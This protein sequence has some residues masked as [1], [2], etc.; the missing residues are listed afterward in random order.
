MCSTTESLAAAVI[1]AIAGL[2]AA[3]GEAP[4]SPSGEPGA[5]DALPD[6]PL[7][8]RWERLRSDLP[9]EVWE[10][11]IAYDPRTRAV[12][13]HGGHVIG[14]YVQ[15]SYTTL[16]ELPSGEVR[17]STAGSRPQR[18]C[19]VDLV[20]LDTIGRVLTGNGSSSHGSLPQGG[21]AADYRSII[22]GDPRGPF[23]YDSVTDTWEDARTIGTQWNRIPHA[24]LA[25]DPVHEAVVY[26]AGDRLVMYSVRTNRIYGRALPEALHGR[27]A[28]GI[29]GT[30]RHGEV[31][32]FGGSGPRSWTT[33]PDRQQAYDEYVHDDT[34]IY[35]IGADAWEEVSSA[36][37]PPKGMPM[38][39]FLKLD[40]VYYEPLDR[41][42]LWTVPVSA[43]PPTFSDW[44][45]P[46]L[47]SFDLGT[48][49]WEI[50]PSSGGPEFPGLLAAA[51]DEE[52]LVLVGGGRDGPPAANP[53][54][55]LSRELW[56]GEVTVPRAL[57]PLAPDPA[58]VSARTSAATVEL[59]WAATEGATYE[60]W[61]APASPFPG[62]FEQVGTANGSSWTDADVEP[63]VVHAYRVVRAG[64]PLSR[65]SSSVFDQPLR[66]GGVTAAVESADRVV[67][68]WQP[69][70]EPD[71]IGYRVYRATGAA[72]TWGGGAR[73]TP[74]PVSTTSFV[75]QDAGLADG[76][77][78]AYWVV[79][80]NELGIESGPS[81]LAYTMPD[82]PPGFRVVVN[83]A[84]DRATIRW[85]WP[86]S[87]GP[88]RFEVSSNDHHENTLDY[89]SEQVAAWWAQWQ[90]VTAE[91]IT[92]NQVEVPLADPER[93]YLF[94]VRAIN[95]LGQRGFY[96]DIASGTD[97]RFRSAAP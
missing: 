7:G 81:P 87:R 64:E 83:E 32:V 45:A 69:A 8:V 65:G 14:S 97:P 55:A 91:P 66:V 43:P 71:V 46:E 94:F 18:R 48:R 68:S 49:T 31:V 85:D 27:K 95:V 6:Q 89:T 13:Q 23:L 90:P 84:R 96:S 92:G 3:C 4:P 62:P 17:A 28:Y 26:I 60:I 56:V 61:R 58:V 5:P 19:L 50:L 73:L 82:A 93:D 72:V 1:V 24:Q 52:A 11:G 57:R 53:R 35:D 34:W 74:T 10:N 39:D 70:S 2:G 47:W 20:Y 75:D 15:S 12:V 38:A 44:P 88:A 30:G 21:P 42:V 54:P 40:L 37:R 79:A 80:V 22:K 36:V 33:F 59:S 78:R 29:T 63:G 51:A 77:L 25:Y 41:V 9:A 16:Y 86:A 67:V 76:V